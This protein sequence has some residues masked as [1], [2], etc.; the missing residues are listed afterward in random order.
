MPP[1]PWLTLAAART[2]HEYLV[3]LTYLPLAGVRGL[4]AFFRYV[5]AIRGQLA[6]TEGVLGYSLRA[7]LLRLQ[8]W[9]LSAWTDRDALNAFVRAEPH[10]TSMSALQGRMGQTRFVYW[11]LPGSQLPPAW[12]DAMARFAK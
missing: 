2:D 4:P 12:T 6:R 8:F 9:T 11:R 3:L 1:T 10:L 7:H 5:Q